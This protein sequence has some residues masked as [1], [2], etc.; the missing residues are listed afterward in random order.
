MYS[1]RGISKYD[2]SDVIATT[3]HAIKTGF[4]DAERVVIGSW[5]QGGFLSYLTATRDGL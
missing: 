5:S 3:D 1:F 2:R 4:V